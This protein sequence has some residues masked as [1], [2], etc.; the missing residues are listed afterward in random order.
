MKSTLKAMAALML[1]M[2]FAVGCNNPKDLK[3]IE[4]ENV[5]IDSVLGLPKG[6]YTMELPETDLFEWTHLSATKNVYLVRPK[7]STEPNRII[8][9]DGEV[10][11]I[12]SFK[13]V[14]EEW[15]SSLNKADV[16]LMICRLNV[17]KSLKMNDVNEVMQVLAD[18]K[19]PR[20][21]Y[22]VVPKNPEIDIQDY[23]YVSL[24]PLWMQG[25]FRGDSIYRE[26]LDG[27]CTIPNQINVV[28][29]GLDAYEINGVLAKG[30]DSKSMLKGL[31]QQDLNNVIRFKMD[32]AM[33]FDDY[34]VIVI[35][36]L[37]ALEELKDEYAMEKYLKHLDEVDLYEEEK[38]IHDHFPFRF[39]EEK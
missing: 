4:V 36:A 31:M 5:Q 17:D 30:E 29:I 27:V 21:Q 34:I 9:V 7:D 12:P 24:H 13:K 22:A 19:T 37:E 32:D 15:K 25:R 28:S 39:F 16:P 33:L 10:L 35:S 18:I 23:A 14:M 11:D 20:I 26:M 3:N 1:M 2:V 8:V 38:E 6:T